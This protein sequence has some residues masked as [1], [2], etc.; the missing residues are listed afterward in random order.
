MES[1]VIQ[2]RE[3]VVSEF[4]DRYV[5]SPPEWGNFR[6]RFVQAVRSGNYLEFLGIDEKSDGYRLYHGTAVSHLSGILESGGMKAF[7]EQE[8]KDPAIFVVPNPLDAIDHMVHNGPHDT[9]RKEGTV[10]DQFNPE[11]AVLLQITLPKDWLAEQ[12]EALHPRP[13]RLP[14]WFREQKGIADTYVPLSSFETWLQDE[15]E[16]IRQGKQGFSFG[17]KLPVAFVPAQFVSVVSPDGVTIPLET[18]VRRLEA[19][20]HDARIVGE[21][22]PE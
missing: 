7:F 13:N 3:H 8:G 1:P 20:I 22:V 15:W 10:A 6:E 21:N 16:T 2:G 19:T 14:Q 12:E 5:P 4:E 18:Y 17:I 11:E 9:L